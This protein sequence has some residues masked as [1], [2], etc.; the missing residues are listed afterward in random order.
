M[1]LVQVIASGLLLGGVYALLAVGLTLIFGVMKLVNFAH[2]DFLMVAMYLV[3][4]LATAFGLSPYVSMPVAAVVMFVIGM[5]TFQFFLRP[6]LTRGHSS[7]IVL[8][9]GI[10]IILQ[11]L[12]LIFFTG[13]YRTLPPETIGFGDSLTI[14]AIHLSTS[15]VISFIVATLSTAALLLFMNH[16][17]MGKAMRATSQDST[18]ALLMGI[19]VNR[20]Y[21]IAMGLGT[22]MV[23]I[24]SSI[25]IPMFPVYP[26]LGADLMILGFVVVVMGG[27]GNII[28]AYVGGLIIGVVEA[29]SALYFGGVASQV[30]YF[31]LFVIVLLVRP[32]GLFRGEVG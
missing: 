32:Q 19:P 15:R 1:I 18:A 24:A 31:L 12:A 23:G 27:L 17:M 28:G 5:A 14:G 10:A 29:V 9:L 6:T 13:N 2:G 25:L 16:T 20:I 4:V 11:S 7:Q 21:L 3:Y 22:S 30:I 8:T 26:T